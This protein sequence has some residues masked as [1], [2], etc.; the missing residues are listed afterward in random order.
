[1]KMYSFNLPVYKQG[2]DLNNQMESHNE[3]AKK[4]LLGLSEQFKEASKM[5]AKFAGVVSEHPEVEVHGDNHQI[6]VEG[7]EDVLDN[8]VKEQL[9]FAEE[10][11]DEDE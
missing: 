5:C 6:Y 9:L 2:D 3:D 8:L 7:P 4:A 10:F 1:M 11:D